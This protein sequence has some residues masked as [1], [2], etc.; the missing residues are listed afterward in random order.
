MA[1]VATRLSQR[2]RAGGVGRSARGAGPE[3]PIAGDTRNAYDTKQQDGKQGDGPEASQE[4][5]GIE[6]SEV[7]VPEVGQPEAGLTQDDLDL[8]GI[9]DQHDPRSEDG[10]QA[11]DGPKEHG[12][13]EQRTH[14]HDGSAGCIAEHEPI[15]DLERHVRQPEDKRPEG[16]ERQAAAVGGS[17]EVNAELQLYQV[18]REAPGGVNRVWCGERRG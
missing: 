14:E 3:T 4:A 7:I 2:K 6:E 10:E 8:A 5:L 9:Q 15:G 17:R 13:A 1:M 16:V 12:S 11:D 18:E